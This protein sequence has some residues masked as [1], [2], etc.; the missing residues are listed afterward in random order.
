MGY[1]FRSWICIFDEAMELRLY[2]GKICLYLVMGFLYIVQCMS[3]QNM[4]HIKR[5]SRYI[6]FWSIDILFRKYKKESEREKQKSVYIGLFIC[7]ELWGIRC[8]K[9]PM[10][11]VHIE[12]H[13]VVFT[14]IQNV[15]AGFG[16]NVYIQMVSLPLPLSVLCFQASESI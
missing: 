7:W 2:H 5:F 9:H 4:L 8:F 10:K 14:H 6:S 15:V 11:R 1:L 12:C 3:H 13:R 16:V